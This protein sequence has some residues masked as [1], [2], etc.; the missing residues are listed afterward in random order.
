MTESLPILSDRMLKAFATKHSTQAV[1]PAKTGRFVVPIPALNDGLGNLELPNAKEL[2]L[3]VKSGAEGMEI[4][5]SKF[6]GFPQIV[7]TDG[8]QVVLI[9]NI[10]ERQAAAMELT[11]EN[12]KLGNGGT[13][14]RNTLIQFFKTATG[15][16]YDHTPPSIHPV[17]DNIGIHGDVFNQDRGT[18]KHRHN[19]YGTD[20]DLTKIPDNKIREGHYQKRRSQGQGFAISGGFSRDTETGT[21]QTFPDT[22]MVHIGTDG[23][24]SAIHKN[25]INVCYE[26]PDGKKLVDEAG[27]IGLPTYSV[28]QVMARG[29]Q[30]TVDKVRNTVPGSKSGRKL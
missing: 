16:A 5:D 27:V 4:T 9:N 15:I 18:F 8:T 20:E 13:M 26:T 19:P 14:D 21:Q 25:D 6:E 1:M 7:P 29:A 22:A 28:D 23:V 10:S 3:V 2:T 11:Y 17:N 24:V 12:M 30:T